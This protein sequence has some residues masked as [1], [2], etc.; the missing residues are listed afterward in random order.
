MKT[1]SKPPVIGEEVRD[2][3]FPW[4]K[5][6]WGLTTFGVGL[7]GGYPVWKDW[8]SGELPIPIPPPAPFKKPGHA[9]AIWDNYQGAASIIVFS[10]TKVNPDGSWQVLNAR[11]YT[12]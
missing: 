7:L 1:M 10:R 6:V 11:C 9:D 2:L 8:K 12:N 4:W 5:F 3:S